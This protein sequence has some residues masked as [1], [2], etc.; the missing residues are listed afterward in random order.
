[1]NRSPAQPSEVDA[2]PIF[3]AGDTVM[4]TSEGVCDVLDVRPMRFGAAQDRLYYVLKPTTIKSSST[5]YMPV[6]RGNS[7]LRRLL[8]RADI[9]RLIAGSTALGELW[10]EDS[11]QRRD[12]FQHILQSGDYT[13]IIRMISEIHKHNEARAASGRKPCASDEAILSE[14][15]HLLHQEFSCVLNLPREETIAYI[16]SRLPA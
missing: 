13:R 15:E 7:V 4:H 10:I 11:R 14:A 5:V 8:S 3:A 12:V 2:E 9:D 1:M 6:L 16:R